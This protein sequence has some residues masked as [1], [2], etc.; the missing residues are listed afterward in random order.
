MGLNPQGENNTYLTAPL[1]SGY[2]WPHHK[3]MIRLAVSGCTPQEI[4]SLTG[5]SGGAI[6]RIL[7]TPHFQAEVARLTEVS[8]DIACDIRED[9]KQLAG[10]AIEV[11]A[12]DVNMEIDNRFDRKLR[13]EAAKDILDRAGFRKNAPVIGGDLHLHKHEAEARG[14]SDKDLQN[15]VMDLVKITSDEYE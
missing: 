2:L 15:D 6:T 13:Q 4:Q 10:S 3:K 1:K 11:L 9:L 7:A 14:M 5:F 8:E 12:E